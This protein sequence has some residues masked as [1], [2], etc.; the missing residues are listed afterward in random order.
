MGL[1]EDWKIIIRPYIGKSSINSKKKSSRRYS[2]TARNKMHSRTVTWKTLFG[3]CFTKNMIAYSHWNANAF[4]NGPLVVMVATRITIVFQ[5]SIIAITL[6]PIRRTGSQAKLAKIH[7]IFQLM[8]SFSLCIIDKGIHKGLSL[9]HIC[10]AN[11][12]L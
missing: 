3:N 6:L 11:K 8:F 1:F 10:C 12:E 9:H 4:I 2:T 7:E 5:Q